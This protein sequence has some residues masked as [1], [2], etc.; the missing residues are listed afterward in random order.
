MFKRGF[1]VVS[2]G[3]LALLLA[4]AGTSPAQYPNSSDWFYAPNGMGGTYYAPR[5][6]GAAPPSPAPI[7][8]TA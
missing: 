5:F 1:P 6:V 8:V 3:A 2:A 4:S 7:P